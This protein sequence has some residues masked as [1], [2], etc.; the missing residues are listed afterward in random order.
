MTMM[1]R[2]IAAEKLQAE[3]LGLIDWV[4]QTQE[5]LI[6]TAVRW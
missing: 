5:P 2:T 3:G 6:V 1:N 4:E